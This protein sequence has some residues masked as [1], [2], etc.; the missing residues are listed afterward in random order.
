MPIQVLNTIKSIEKDIA[1]MTAKSL[2][3]IRERIDMFGETVCSSNADILRRKFWA[4][5]RS[6]ELI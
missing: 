5:A 4:Q 1:A 2:T 3:T 6:L